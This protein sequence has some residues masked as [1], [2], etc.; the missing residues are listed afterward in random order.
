MK[1]TVVGGG[2][3]AFGFSAGLKLRGLEVA[4]L[5]APEFEAS[6]QPV[7][8]KGGIQIKGI[9]GDGHAA[10]DLVTTD[11]Q[12]ALEAA[13]LIFVCV[14]SYALAR[15][16]ELIIPHLHSGQIIL[17]MPGNCGGALVFAEQIKQAGGSER[18]IVAEA[19]SF[20]LA[21]KKEGPAGVWVRGIKR[22]LPV[23]AFP[24]KETPRVVL[25]LKGVFSEFESA[26]HVLETSLNNANHIVHPPGI[27]LNLGLV[28][29]A[30]E[31]W[32]FFFQGLSRGVCTVM[33]AMDRER[34]ETL[35]LLNLDPVSTLEWLLRFYK[36]QGLKG[37]SLFQA[38]STTPIH[39][40]SK[41]PRSLD[42]RYI[43]ED[44]PYGLVPLSSI[45]RELGVQTSIMDTLIRLAG[46]V[47]GT[48]WRSEG[49]TTDK[50]G[51][52]GMSASRMVEYVMEGE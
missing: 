5:E 41:G 20:L 28:E 38:L 35:K 48:D 18:P 19:S 24:G 47:T 31:D 14:P 50:M 17:L 6:I 8:E 15:M 52:S 2:N 11:A 42:H 3:A 9:L 40:P 39:G 45:G 10:L 4:L 33:E 1:V 26:H 43:T 12:E 27:L 36:D 37:D 23:A 46:L 49:W 7:K 30:K 51:L 29:L 34:I 32:S 22:G 16:A 21:C 25:T 44:I 13:S